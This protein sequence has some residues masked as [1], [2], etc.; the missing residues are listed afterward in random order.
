M[1][2]RG[3]A[4]PKNGNIVLLTLLSKQRNGFLRSREEDR[5]R[6]D[7]GSPWGKIKI[8]LPLVV[9]KRE[10]KEGTKTGG[11]QKCHATMIKKLTK[12]FADKY[13]CFLEPLGEVIPS[14]E[15][16]GKKPAK[17]RLAS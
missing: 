17:R 6:F 16:Q 14:S 8:N 3:L 5:S 10:S 13:S 1:G 15:K 12:V 7:V 2:Y 9:D 11:A 4:L